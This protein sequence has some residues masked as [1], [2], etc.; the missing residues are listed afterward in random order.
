MKKII[1]DWRV[2]TLNRIKEFFNNAHSTELDN[3]LDNEEFTFKLNIYFFPAVLLSTIGCFFFKQAFWFACI[4]IG[5]M[6]FTTLLSQIYNADDKNSY[7][8][9]IN[10]CTKKEGIIFSLLMIIILFICSIISINLSN[11]VLNLNNK[12]VA[13]LGYFVMLFLTI[14]ITSIM[15]TSICRLLFPLAIKKSKNY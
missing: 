15:F 9:F 14:M 8:Q 5:V 6:L 12:L 7:E 1:N 13:S 3:L 4:T 10:I 11:I 2:K